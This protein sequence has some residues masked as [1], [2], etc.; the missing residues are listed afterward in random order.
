MREKKM[1]NSKIS[2]RQKN[3]ALQ[4]IK[5]L[6][7]QVDYDTRDYPI[8]YIVKKF[9][10]EVIFAP[11]YQRKQN[12]WS[13]RDKARLIE[14]L[15]LGYPIPIIFL[16]DTSEG[17]LE[18]VDGLQRINAL[19]EF[20]ENKL[21]LP[22]L[23]KLTSLKGFYYNDLPFSEMNRFANK[24]LRIIVLRKSTDE[25]TRIDL[26][27]RINTSGKSANPAE[28]RNGA[29][30]LNP[31]MKVVKKLAS[32]PLFLNLVNLSKK[33]LTRLENIELVSRF[34]AYS[35]NYKAFKHSVSD[36]VASY[37]SRKSRLTSI[38]RKKMI[39]DFYSTFYFIKKNYPD[40]IFKNKNGQT[41]RVRFEAIS[42]G[43]NLALQK[44]KASA[45]EKSKMELQ[46]MVNSEKFKEYTTSDGANN[47][48]LV[49]N[50]I[51]FVR[52]FLLTS[53]K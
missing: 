13:N 42:V 16:S 48:K 17:K 3:I 39:N 34:F 44:D 22:A 36:F 47:P 38:E 50:R 52:N 15:L 6:Q 10:K 27:N 24:S 12:A 32:D 35:D 20:Y 41:P 4:Q 30:A 40:N 43:T 37:F 7:K 26:F 46:E 23:E 14:S 29:D 25:E 33:K 51:E 28:V 11:T 18:I 19:T 21:K 8:E 1:T 5:S 2:N 45:E 9:L 31:A 53:N 49:S